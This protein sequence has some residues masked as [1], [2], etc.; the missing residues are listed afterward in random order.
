MGKPVAVKTYTMLG[1]EKSPGVLFL[2]ME[3]IFKQINMEQGTSHNI[4]YSYFEIY[5]DRIIDLLDVEGE[6]EV[7]LIEAK[8]GTRLY[9]LMQEN[10]NNLDEISQIIA[11]CESVRHTRETDYN[12]R[13]SRSH[14]IF[15]IFLEKTDKETNQVYTSTIT[16]VD[17]AGSERA[18]LE[19]GSPEKKRETTF[20]NKSLLSIA[21]VIGKL[22]DP[23]QKHAH[24]PYRDSK[25]T[26]ILQPILSGCS[27]KNMHN[28]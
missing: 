5:N 22:A 17:L 1:N 20:I 6:K 2:A 28:L 19:C 4:S 3:G 24:I 27:A 15:Q 21:T 11:K 25:L 16:M 26:R 13:S 18:S 12:E 9:N 23:K 8:E 7:K 14:S 10:A